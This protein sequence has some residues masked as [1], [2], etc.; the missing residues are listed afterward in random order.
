MLLT[1]P[2]PFPAGPRWCRQTVDDGAHTTEAPATGV[3][4]LSVRLIMIDDM[5]AA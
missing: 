5:I 2:R 3:F 4:D 1:L